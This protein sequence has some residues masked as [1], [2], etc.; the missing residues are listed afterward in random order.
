MKHEHNW[1]E[2][3]RRDERYVMARVLVIVLILIGVSVWV[4]V[5]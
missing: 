5:R 1:R 4:A 2:Q 3:M